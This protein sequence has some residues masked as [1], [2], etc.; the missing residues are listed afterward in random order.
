MSGRLPDLGYIY[1]VD[2]GCA[3]SGFG[4]GPLGR[5]P[6]F[7]YIQW[8]LEVEGVLWHASGF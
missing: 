8:I 2:Q 3:V 7:R 4:S 1:S 6:E 5:V